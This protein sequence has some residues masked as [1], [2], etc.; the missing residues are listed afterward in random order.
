MIKIQNIYYMLAYAYQAI[1]N[2]QVKK[3]GSEEFDYIEDLFAVILIKSIRLQLRRGLLRDYKSFDQVME[4]PKGKIIVPKTVREVA[5]HSGKVACRVE[6]YTE[7][8]YANQIIKATARVL[9]HSSNVRMSNKNELKSLMRYFDFV[10]S[11]AVYNVRWSSLRFTGQNR[12]YVMMMNVC[13][14]I[15]EEQLV[16]QRE[17]Q[18]LFQDISEKRLFALYQRFVFEYYR[19]HFHSIRVEA[20]HL[21]WDTDDDY[22][23]LLPDMET[24][25]TL[26]YKGCTLIIDTKMYNDPLQTNRYGNKTIRSSHL[27]QIF[28]YVKNWK[29]KQDKVSGMLL[30]AA[31]E[32]EKPNEEYSMS[33]NRISVKTLDLDVDFS[34]LSSQLDDIVNKWLAEYDLH[35]EKTL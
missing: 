17:G 5:N 35:C 13:R 25:I 8:T 27:Y 6:E 34:C 32:N 15:L 28:A 22:Q 29:N 2:Q 19:Y 1:E 16:S 24:D 20:P 9:L 11:I 31:S 4:A 26:Q 23:Q 3:L 14:I 21:L 12:A 30:Y 7:N 10:D 18:Y 33:G